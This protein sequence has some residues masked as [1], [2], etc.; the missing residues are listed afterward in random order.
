MNLMPFINQLEAKGVGKKGKTL[1]INMLPIDISEG[2]LLRNS[3]TG[4]DIDYELPGYFRTEFQVIV[5]AGSY[6]AGE[7]LINKVTDSL[8]LT[9]EQLDGLFFNYVRPRTEPVT[10]PL[11]EG[12]L[13]EF[14]TY[15]SL[16]FYKVVNSA[17]KELS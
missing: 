4:T 14:S 2:V 7:K 11:S 1:F 10:Y 5:R 6:E 3:L 17:K 13:L 8:T 12:N 16:S 15:F 9:N